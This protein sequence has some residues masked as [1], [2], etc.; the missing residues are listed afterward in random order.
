M[1]LNMNQIPKNDHVREDI[2]DRI[3]QYYRTEHWGDR[4]WN[5]FQEETRFCYYCHHWRT[6]QR[7]HVRITH[8][9]PFDEHDYSN[10]PFAAY[11]Q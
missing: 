1:T 3:N 9:I 2:N 10:V 11:D 4:D 6:F 8:A 5:L 7:H